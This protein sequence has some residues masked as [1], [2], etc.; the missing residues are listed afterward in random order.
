MENC[1]YY[2]EIKEVEPLSK[3]SE[4][5]LDA[6]RLYCKDGLNEKEKYELTHK[7]RVKICGRCNGTRERE[8]CYCNGDPTKCPYSSER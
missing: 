5:F 1:R 2:E 8:Q 7:V 4:G 3:Y 6:K